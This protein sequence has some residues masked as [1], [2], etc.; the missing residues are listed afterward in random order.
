MLD[1]YLIL[2]V[3]NVSYE[4]VLRFWREAQDD[5]RCYLKGGRA[6]VARSHQWERMTAVN[7]EAES[8]D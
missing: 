2:Y 3:N 6:A 1:S 7:R 8:V 4:D 5:L